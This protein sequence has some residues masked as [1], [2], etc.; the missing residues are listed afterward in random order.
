M[1]AAQYL[2]KIIYEVSS[3]LRG[4]LEVGR[5]FTTRFTA[6]G[7]CECEAQTTL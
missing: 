1:S 5:Y 7:T 4:N 3:V 6:L 2:I